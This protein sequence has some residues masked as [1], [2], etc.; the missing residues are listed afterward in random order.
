MTLWPLQEA[1]RQASMAT[2]M[3]YNGPE[4]HYIVLGCISSFL[5][6]GVQP[7]VAIVFGGLLGVS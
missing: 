1:V 5:H 2:L 4:W 6:G 3:R 7:V